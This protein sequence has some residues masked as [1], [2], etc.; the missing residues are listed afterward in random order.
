ME[1]PGKGIEAKTKTVGSWGTS[2]FILKDV[3]FCVTKKDEKKFE[4]E[5][6]QKLKAQLP[7]FHLQILKYPGPEIVNFAHLVLHIETKHAW[8]FFFAYQNLVVMPVWILSFPETSH[9]GRHPLFLPS[10]LAPSSWLAPWDP[11]AYGNRL[12]LNWNFWDLKFHEGKERLDLQQLSFDKLRM[13]S[14]FT[15]R[16]NLK[17][18]WGWNHPQVL[19]ILSQANICLH[20]PNSELIPCS[21]CLCSH[22]TGENTWKATDTWRATKPVDSAE[23]LRWDDRANKHA[24]IIPK[25]R[26]EIP[27][28]PHKAVAE[29][30]R[31]GN[32]RR[33]WLL[34]VTDGR[35]KTLMDRTVQLCNW[36]TDYLT[37]CRTD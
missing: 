4:S 7:Q 3:I 37:D 11:M 35:A 20:P 22:A 10:M 26:I 29:V 16:S 17:W 27:V 12:G 36:L 14:I 28:V 6:P 32:Y 24:G 1:K 31:I 15:V 34:W 5:N 23:S 2:S 19:E 18:S 30:S 21:S 33:D 25:V 13:P 8:Q 9:F